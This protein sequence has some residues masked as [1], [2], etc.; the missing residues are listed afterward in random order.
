MKELSKFKFFKLNLEGENFFFNIC[1][2]MNFLKYP[3][4]WEVV[5]KNVFVYC[6]QELFGHCTFYY[7]H[8]I[9]FAQLHYVFF[10]HIASFF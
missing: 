2:L 3:W 8:C 10:Q 5:V 1:L 6:V 7:T 4:F 9:S